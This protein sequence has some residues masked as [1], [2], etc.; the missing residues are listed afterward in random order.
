[1]LA[2]NLMKKEKPHSRRLELPDSTTQCYRPPHRS[3]HAPLFAVSSK[4][5]AQEYLRVSSLLPN[6]DEGSWLG[7][8][9]Y[10]L[11]SEHVRG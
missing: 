9:N 10:S 5:T 4:P 2:S 8:S 3:C 6:T 11:F 1:M 7:K